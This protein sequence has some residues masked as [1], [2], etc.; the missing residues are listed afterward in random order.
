MSDYYLVKFVYALVYFCSK[1][2]YIYSYD[3]GHLFDY[4]LCSIFFALVLFKIHLRLFYT[5]CAY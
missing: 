1:I 5:I 4:L 2:I 3:S